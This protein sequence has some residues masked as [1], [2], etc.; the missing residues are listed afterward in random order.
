MP[1]HDLCT[2]RLP[3]NSKNG[4]LHSPDSRRARDYSEPPA[5]VNRKNGRTVLPME[6]SVSPESRDACDQ[7]AIS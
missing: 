7:G 2:G 4:G 5:T 1:S 6:P 3:H